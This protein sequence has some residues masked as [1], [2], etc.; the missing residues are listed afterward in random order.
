[1]ATGQVW[2]GGQVPTLDDPLFK[3]IVKELED[4]EG[5]VEETWESRVPTSL[6]VIQ[7]GSIGLDVEGL[8]CDPDC[9]EYIVRDENGNIINTLTNPIAQ[10]SHLM[11]GPLP[12]PV[13]SEVNDPEPLGSN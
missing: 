9:D 7:A 1:M 11:G 2:N 12:Q 3:S 8:P 10:K 6:T 4:T 13:N 5:V